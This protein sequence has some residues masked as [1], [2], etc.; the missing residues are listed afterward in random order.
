VVDDGLYELL[1]WVV[2]LGVDDEERAVE[3]VLWFI[4]FDELIG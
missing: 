3:S 4:C 2:V 1:V